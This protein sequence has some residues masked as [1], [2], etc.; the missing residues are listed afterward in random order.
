MRPLRL[1]FRM[2]AGLVLVGAVSAQILPLDQVRAGQRGVGR[3]V[4]AG[5]RVEEFQVEI[6]GVL[7]N[8][9]PKQSLILGRLSGGPLAETGVMAGMSGS[10]VYIDGKLAGAVA[11]SFPFSTEPLAGIRPIEDM[12][13]EDASARVEPARP[14]LPELL[15]GDRS[16]LPGPSGTRTAERMIPIATPVSFGGFTERTIEVFGDQLRALGLRPVQGVG[17]QARDG[18]SAAVE[19]GSMISVGMLRG[20]L[21]MS[22]A[23]TVTQVEGD[24]LWAFGHAFLSTGPLELPMMRASVLTLVPNVQNSFKLAGEGALI[25]KVTL[26]RT[27]GIAG[28]LGPGPSMVPFRLRVNGQTY[29]MEAVRDP[30]LTPF[31]LQ[32][33]TF[34]AIDAEQRQLGPSSLRIHGRVSFADAP[35]L[36]LD[37]LYSGASGVAQQAAIGTAAPLAFLQQTAP[38]DLNVE[39]I[40]IDIDAA[41]QD[42]RIRVTGAW[43]DRRR[44][45][46][47]E[48]VK[49]SVAL[50]GPGADERTVRELE[51][52]APA[53]IAPGP[54]QL[55]LSDA[56]RLNTTEFPLLLEAGTLTPSELVHAV[57]RLRRSDAL[58]LRVWRSGVGFRVQAQRMEQ[59]P[60]SLR[61]ILESPQGAAGGA[62]PESYEVLA[63]LNVATFNGVV[64]GVLSLPLEITQ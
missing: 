39:R 10:P 1:L 41:P 3:T 9:G 47:G 49:I 17:G 28:S 58:Y 46:A 30:F 57:N 6:L 12:L 38:A 52:T 36:E 37:D 24:R 33:A 14:S 61:T 55:T 51:W 54:L 63:E 59:V 31:L 15:A 5:D 32:I 50:R 62:S 27:A 8:V 42:R 29:D 18:G 26:D 56:A 21:S 13:R 7:E 16:I 44:M 19:P 40:E 34:S 43:T 45:Q 35:P 60:A 20:D 22:A 64:D 25:G 23:G 53:A 11:F 4:F 2:A 48:T